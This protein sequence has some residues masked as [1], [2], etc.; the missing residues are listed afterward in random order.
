M[1]SAAVI[2]DTDVTAL[3]S[4][5]VDLVQKDHAVSEAGVFLIAILQILHDVP[6]ISAPITCFRQ[7]GGI[8][9]QK[10]KSYD[11][12]GFPYQCCFSAAGGA[13]EQEIGTWNGTVPVGS[14]LLL[15]QRDSHRAL[16]TRL[17]D[18]RLVQFRHDLLRCQDAVV[19]RTGCLFHAGQDR[20]RN[21]ETHSADGFA[22][23]TRYMVV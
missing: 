20:L 19:V 12:G 8:K 16:G 10:R 5:F 22:G 23:G 13:V 14:E 15:P 7:S 17:S 4:Q 11:T 3:C 9:V 6:R 18:D 2:L 1:L 21:L